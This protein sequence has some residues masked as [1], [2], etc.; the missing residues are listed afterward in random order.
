ML[1]SKRDASN[2]TKQSNTNDCSMTNHVKVNKT[3]NF[4]DLDSCVE[5][6]DSIC[7]FPRNGQTKQQMQRKLSMN[8]KIT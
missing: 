2:R 7:N 4:T 1:V 8:K 3:C 6:Y 5:L